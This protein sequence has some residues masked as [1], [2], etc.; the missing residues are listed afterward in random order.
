MCFYFVRSC[1]H[2]KLFRTGVEMFVKVTLMFSSQT[3]A[4]HSQMDWLSVRSS[5][6]TD[7]IYCKNQHWVLNYRIIFK[8]I[9]CGTKLV[10]ERN[11]HK[12][13]MHHCIIII[14]SRVMHMITI[15][16]PWY[17][18]VIFQYGMFLVPWYHL[19]LGIPAGHSGET[20]VLATLVWLKP[21]VKTVA[22]LYTDLFFL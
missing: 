22:N 5:T 10:K 12:L 15:P 7:P 20:V 11:L 3:W 6:N 19:F 16:L 1:V 9:A 4:P 8:K 18:M 2:W 14:L 17:S 13:S 21:L